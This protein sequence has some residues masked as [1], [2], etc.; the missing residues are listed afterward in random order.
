MLPY[1]IALVVKVINN[2]CRLIIQT[3]SEKGESSAGM[4]R[5]EAFKLI[6]GIFYFGGGRLM[7]NLLK[8]GPRQLTGKQFR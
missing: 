5:K 1:N 7:K 8:I 6:T 2:S 3:P 4:N